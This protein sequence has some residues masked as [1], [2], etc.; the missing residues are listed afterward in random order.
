MFISNFSNTRGSGRDPSDAG[1]T[2]LEAAIVLIAFVVVAAVFAY[3]VLAVGILFSGESRATVHQGVQQ[4][5]SAC[6]VTGTIYGISETSGRIDVILVPVGLTVG[7]EPIDMT[8]VSVRLVGP[9]HMEELQRNDPLI[10]AT[11]DSG[12]WSVR[13]RLNGDADLVLEPGEQYTLSI[14]PENR[15]DCVPYGTF[16]VEIKP[17]GRAALRVEKTVPGGL[18]RVTRL[19]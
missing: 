17:A 8:T 7:S 5:G 1:F 16:A 9:H 2:G 14:A 18:E 6:T 11:P 3:T 19:D 15:V 12:H 4:A 10:A 13:E